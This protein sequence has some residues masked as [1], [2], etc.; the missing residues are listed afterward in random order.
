MIVATTGT[1]DFG[2]SRMR[3]WVR[4]MFDFINSTAGK[5]IVTVTSAVIVAILTGTFALVWNTNSRQIQI[6]VELKN[7]TRRIDGM[8]SSIPEFRLRVAHE[9]VYGPFA[10]AILVTDPIE[11]SSGWT[12]SI[13]IVD[14]ESGRVKKLTDRTV[15]LPIEEK[16]LAFIGGMNR[17]DKGATSFAQLEN[18]G[19]ELKLA[20]Y[21]PLGIDKDLSFISSKHPDQIDRAIKVFKATDDGYFNIDPT[22]NW[23]TLV[24]GINIKRW[25]IRSE[26]R[27]LR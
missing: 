14:A 13:F 11:T 25:L 20:K 7:V 1:V 8:V 10:T 16:N 6:D 24:D 26:S 5:I 17:L 9:A 23:A 4:P 27:E 21:M 3:A 12:R 2:R 18:F 15:A 22:H 19:V